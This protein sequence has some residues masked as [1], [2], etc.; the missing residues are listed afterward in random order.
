M[1]PG[2]GSVDELLYEG[3]RVEGTVDLDD[4]RVVVTTHRVL[5]FTP[6]FEGANFMDVDRP[7]VVGVAAGADA[8][9]DHL[10]RGV[11]YGIIGLGLIG[12]GLLIDF[13]AIVGDV[14]LGGAGSERVGIGGVLGLVRSL[15]GMIRELDELMQVFGALALVVS[16]VFFGVY[17]LTRDPTIAIEVAGDDDVHVPRPD[18][19]DVESIVSRLEDELDPATGATPDRVGDPLRDPRN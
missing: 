8:E 15:L 12:A 7:N 3:E 6:E 1:A 17:L 19:R 5:A 10:L 18:E 16:V 9:P 4:G 11:K 14:Q 2:R 13:D